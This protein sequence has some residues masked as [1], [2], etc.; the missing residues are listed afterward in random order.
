MDTFD[1]RRLTDHDFELVCG[2]LLSDVLGLPLEVF[3]AGRDG[4]VDLRH[5]AVVV[6][7]KHWV[8]SRPSALIRHLVKVELPKVRALGVKRYAIATSASLTVADKDRLVE[9]FHPFLRG[10]GD[11]FGAEQL[12]A[13]LA[14]RPEVVRR[15]FRL[16][17]SSTAVLRTLLS[18]EIVRRSAWLAA[19]LAETAKTFV[20]HAGFE[21]ARETL[22][23]TSVCVITGIPGIGKT[24][25]AKMLALWLADDGYEIVEISQDAAEIAELW[26]ASA[27]QVF[28]YDDFL[29]STTLESLGKNEDHRLL[30]AMRQISTAPGKALVMTTRGYVLEQARQ[31]HRVLGEADLDPMTSVVEL[32]D[33][34]PE[35]RAHILYNHVHNSTLPVEEKRRFA[36]PDLWR[37]IVRHPN[38]NPRLVERTL[39]LSEPGEMIANLD[40]P[41]RIWESILE[42]ELPDAA[43]HLLEVVFTLEST[44]EGVREAWTSYRQALSFRVTAGPSGRHCASSTARWSWSS[45]PS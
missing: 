14:A 27:R 2:D 36:D 5:D 34:T 17:L 32:S 37:P 45:P 3:P 4:G 12:V 28:V 42:D 18:Q 23:A 6:Q 13:L 29:G 15:H 9:A 31:R 1:L 16:W 26:D 35:I 30:K 19:D 7:C 44:V 39:A 21:S 40:H 8:H 24:T 11:V 20:P 43:V 22:A 41:R 25:I 33:L 10:T 38:F